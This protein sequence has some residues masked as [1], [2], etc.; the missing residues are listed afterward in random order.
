MEHVDSSGE[1]MSNKPMPNKDAEMDIKIIKELD[2]IVKEDVIKA[3]VDSFESEA[4]KKLKKNSGIDIQW[5]SIPIDLFGDSLPD[6]IKSSWVFVIRS[7]VSTGPERHPN[8]HQRMMSYRDAGKIQTWD[9]KR[10]LTRKLVS[11]E[12]EPLGKRWI[13]IPENVFHRAVTGKKTWV[14]VSFHTVPA[15]ELVEERAPI[16]D[17][18]KVKK[19]RYIRW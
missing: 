12:E 3:I 14:V 10:W 8:S 4:E 5:L 6:C 15:N 7:N 1:E 18:S 9:G 11:T 2:D 19:Q 16:D 13:S 17:L